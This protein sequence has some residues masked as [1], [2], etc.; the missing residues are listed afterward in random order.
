MNAAVLILDVGMRP[1]RVVSWQSAIC[2]LFL[3]KV[4]IVEYSQD[5]TIQGV[6][7]TWPMPSVVRVARYFKRDLVQVKFSRL[8]VYTRDG[9]ACQYCGIR[10]NSEDL[11]FDHVKPRARGGRTEWQNIVAACVDCNTKKGSR[12]PS[13]VSECYN[14]TFPTEGKAGEFVAAI[15]KLPAI[16]SATRYKGKVTIFFLP[17]LHTQ[18]VIEELQG[19]GAGT[20]TVGMELI[21]KVRKP[22]YL[23]SVTV[24]MNSNRIPEEWKPYWTTVLDD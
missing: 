10:F 12:L 2:D 17:K 6:K 23:P 4:E 14:F 24:K 11:T 16:V 5:R 21:K 19:L 15:Q 22:S 1:L 7:E 9:F 8:N 13:E 3:G 18:D 20:P